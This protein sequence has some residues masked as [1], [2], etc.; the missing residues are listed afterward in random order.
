MKNNNNDSEL[1]ITKQIYAAIIE[2]N[3][4]EVKTL[5]KGNPAHLYEDVV[6]GSWLHLAV[7]ENQLEIVK[8]LIDFGL[9][10]NVANKNRGG[11]A[12]SVAA[13]EGH[14]EMVKYLLKRGA[15]VNFEPP[16]PYKDVLFSAILSGSKEVVQ[17]LI[18]HGVDTTIRYF[19]RKDAALMAKEQNQ[20]EILAL[21]QAH[22]ATLPADHVPRTTP[23]EE[24]DEEDY[25]EDQYEE[26]K[27]ASH[28]VIRAAFEEV[29]GPVQMTYRERFPSEVPIEAHIIAPSTAY[30]YY[31]LF[32]T[33]MSD[34]A[35][36]YNLLYVENMM[37]V[38]ANWL[39][40]GA[41]WSDKEKTWPL[42]W[43]VELA[44]IPHNENVHPERGVIV[45][46]KGELVHPYGIETHLSCML[47]STPT[48]SDI[49][50][51]PIE[52]KEIRIDELVP[53]YKAEWQYAEANGY[54][55]LQEKLTAA[56]VQEV[57]DFQRP[58]VV[59]MSA[60]EG[61]SKSIKK[62]KKLSNSE[63]IR[64][65]FEK[66]YGPIALQ[67]TD[68][69][70]ESDPAIQISGNII[71]PTKKH[72]YYVVCT[73][74]VSNDLSIKEPHTHVIRV[75]E[76]MMKLP[77]NWVASEEEWTLPE[78]NWPLRL[79]AEYGYHVRKNE[80]KVNS[81]TTFPVEGQV[82]AILSEYTEMDHLLARKP[83][84]KDA[85]GE[86]NEM[87]FISINQLIPIYESEMKYAEGIYGV[88]LIHCLEKQQ[89][90]NV[91]VV[92]RPPSV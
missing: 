11:T 16:H 63:T 27:P 19:E 57:I 90:D 67:F 13:Q 76:M 28:A 24:Y 55:A 41:D 35:L 38:P 83:R 73:L 20:T 78:K 51:L 45:P 79:M 75:N 64:Q 1:V 71:Y 29:Y 7:R 68:L 84:E 32:T 69:L 87:F 60:S 33:G 80:L 18:D 17:L 81:Y 8:W 23:K 26:E 9:D 91:L 92:N 30:P 74:G 89:A 37:K 5:I 54:A 47:I 49:Q 10:V 21:I 82:A 25:E 77:L 72:P 42:N 12:L 70:E 48:D 88:D 2:G 86:V 62:P 59:D 34:E 6:T 61:P 4:E 65:T 15:N 85:S 44:N 40:G 43:L 53:I 56:Q 66:E 46:N 58:S 36:G 3:A 22:N 39:D 50:R 14:Y 52:G 31:V